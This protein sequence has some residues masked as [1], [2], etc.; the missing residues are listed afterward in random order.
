MKWYEYKIY[1]RLRPT[2]YFLGYNTKLKC[3]V[4]LKK[5][6]NLAWGEYVWVAI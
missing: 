5:Q 4:I 6:F 3:F 2:R 1:F